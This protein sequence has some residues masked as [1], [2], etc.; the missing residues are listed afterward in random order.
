MQL[1]SSGRV[2]KFDVKQI[3]IDGRLGESK[4]IAID[5]S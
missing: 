4:I 2:F 5:P 3:S 1:K